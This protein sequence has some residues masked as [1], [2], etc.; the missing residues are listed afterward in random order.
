MKEERTE[1]K[2]HPTAT[3]AIR[4]IPE[5]N[6]KQLLALGTWLHTTGIDIMVIE[7]TNEYG[8]LVTF[9]YWE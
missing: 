2:D 6:K 9:R 7:N 4:G 8:D 5:M 1:H 3:I